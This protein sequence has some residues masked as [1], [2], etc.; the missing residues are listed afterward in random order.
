[1]K[2][3]WRFDNRLPYILHLFLV[4]DRH[5]H[6]IGMVRELDGDLKKSSSICIVMVVN[7]VVVV[8]VLVVVVV[9]VV[10]IMFV[11]RVVDMAVGTIDK[12]RGGFLL[13]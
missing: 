10:V 2:G 1:L 11:G 5:R 8:N 9:H 3:V 12:D 13:V 4:C 6:P 7:V